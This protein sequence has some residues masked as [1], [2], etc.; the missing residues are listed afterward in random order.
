MIEMASGKRVSVFS[1]LWK[2]ALRLLIVAPHERDDEMM[3][4]D[5]RGVRGSWSEIRDYEHGVPPRRSGG[6]Q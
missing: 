1:A 2:H 4:E 3:E 5:L 6:W